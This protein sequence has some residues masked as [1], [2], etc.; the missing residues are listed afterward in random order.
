MSRIV[1]T[2]QV[3]RRQS[4]SFP[5][6]AQLL[7]GVL[8]LLLRPGGVGDVLLDL[9][10]SCRVHSLAGSVERPRV[11]IGASLAG[12]LVSSVQHSALSVAPER[13]EGT[14][15]VEVNKMDDGQTL[16]SNVTFLAGGTN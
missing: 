14:N 7:L 16:L 4:K 9:Q 12:T 10:L 6:K 1:R 8:D 2:Q 3:S 13:S 11:T 5:G 15:C